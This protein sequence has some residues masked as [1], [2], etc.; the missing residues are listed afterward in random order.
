MVM[1]A[2]LD[3]A[4]GGILPIDS[5]PARVR[6]VIV[7]AAVGIDPLGLL[8]DE[9]ES[10]TGVA[11]PA[12]ALSPAGAWLRRHLSTLS[13]QDFKAHFRV[14]RGTF[15][16]VH[17]LVESAVWRCRALPR[18]ADHKWEALEAAAR[19]VEGTGR[20]DDAGDHDGDVVLDDGAAAAAASG[21][22]GNSRFA[23]TTR[24]ELA[25]TLLF[26]ASASSERTMQRQ[27]GVSPRTL[28][29]VVKRVVACL[30]VVGVPEYLG[31][32]TSLEEWNDI[33]MEFYAASRGRMF[34]AIGAIDDTHLDVKLPK[35]ERMGAID[36]DAQFTVHVQAV[37]TAGWRILSWRVGDA[38]AR[39]DSGVL[40]ESALWRAQEGGQPF[41][42]E[43]AFLLGDAG[44]PC[45][46]WL[47][48][49]WSRRQTGD[50]TQEQLRFNKVF[51]SQRVVVEQLF[52]ILKSQWQVLCRVRQ[53]AQWHSLQAV[54]K[55]SIAAA[56]LHNAALRNGD[57]TPAQLFTKAEQ[58]DHMS[59]RER[60]GAML[61]ATMEEQTSARE[62]L[63][64]VHQH[65]RKHTQAG[66]AV[67]RR[68]S[69]EVL[70]RL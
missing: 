31:W 70:A 19:A 21:G 38:G 68:V 59:F 65:H 13:D 34:G 1:A 43:G 33:A 58:I 18:S 35:G 28:W 52:G 57:V 39:Q 8:G 12:P 14:S 56:V 42:P 53:Y 26:M 15:E 64:G 4:L 51:C 22:N 63:Q 27:V 41:I 5:L 17:G 9:E 69:Q 49:P 45:R 6:T 55:Y 29:R 32:P 66:F 48:T 46:T 60:R 40:Q 61:A 62:G 10:D 44:F 11:A 54:R 47:L 24:E 37:C 23:L 16:Q 36:R 7:A 20:D 50:V 30:G 67:L 3:V 25:T 2:Q